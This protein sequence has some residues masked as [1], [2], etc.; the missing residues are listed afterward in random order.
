MNVFADFLFYLFECTKEFI[1]EHELFRW[2]SVKSNVEFVLSHP[3]GWKGAQQHQM[4]EAAVEAGLVADDDA[5]RKQ[6]S[7]VTEGEASLHFCIAQKGAGGI[8][9][10]VVVYV[11]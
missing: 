5:G 11:M 8:M 2:D 9:V 6:I 1:K 3:N 4:R 7:F 10:S